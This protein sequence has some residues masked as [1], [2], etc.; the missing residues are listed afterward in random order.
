MEVPSPGASLRF[1]MAQLVEDLSVFFDAF[2]V[3]VVSGAVTSKGILDAPTNIM[4]DSMVLSNDYVLTAKTADFGGLLYGDP[5]TV[6][7]VNYQVRENR[8]V[9]DGKL[10]EILLTKV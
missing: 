10:C 2:A 6:D 5:I 1:K 8:Q 4:G 9:E 3:T 7:G